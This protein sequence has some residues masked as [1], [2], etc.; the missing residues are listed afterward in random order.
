MIIPDID[1][2]IPDIDNNIDNKHNPTGCLFAKLSNNV[3]KLIKPTQ[4]TSRI[5]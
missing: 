4:I 2:I 1:M 5:T 3:N